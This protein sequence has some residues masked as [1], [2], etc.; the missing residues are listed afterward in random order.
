MLYAVLR[1]YLDALK[2]E[3]LSNAAEKVEHFIRNTLPKGRCSIEHCAAGMRIP[4]RTLQ[5]RLTEERQSF[6]TLLNKQR[7]EL[8]KQQLRHGKDA[9]AQIALELGYSDQTSFCRAFR[10]W[11]GLSPRSYRQIAS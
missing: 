9:L 1:N 3:R 11:T 10:R 4:V 2:N 7:L 8:A 5:R 6:S